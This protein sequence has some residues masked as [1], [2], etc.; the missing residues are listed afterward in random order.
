[1]R[2]LKRVASFVITLLLCVESLLGNGASTAM[3]PPLDEA[4]S[5]GAAAQAADGRDKEKVVASVDVFWASYDEE[6]DQRYDWNDNPIWSQ[7]PFDLARAHRMRLTKG[8]RLAAARPWSF[9][10]HMRRRPSWRIYL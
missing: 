5:S 10:R 2:H 8:E 7:D 6:G 9:R 4:F 1:M 3:A